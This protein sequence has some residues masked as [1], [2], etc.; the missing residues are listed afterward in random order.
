M[1][2]DLSPEGKAKLEAAVVARVVKSLESETDT[3]VRDIVRQ[4]VGNHAAEHT[5]K[6]WPPAVAKIEKRI[7]AHIDALLASDFV[8]KTI[9]EYAKPALRD[10]IRSVINGLVTAFRTGRT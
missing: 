4:W 1:L 9:D 2:A 3:A 7:A 6:S 10:S 5:K 8:D